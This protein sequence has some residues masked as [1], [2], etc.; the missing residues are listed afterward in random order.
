MEDEEFL[1]SLTSAWL[2]EER[3]A[4]PRETLLEQIARRGPEAMRAEIEPLVDYYDE[5]AGYLPEAGEIAEALVELLDNLAGDAAPACAR[6]QE[7]HAR[8]AEV[9]RAELG[10]LEVRPSYSPW[11]DSLRAQLQAF[12]RGQQSRAPIYEQLA[13]LEQL[14]S[15][16]LGQNRANARQ[17]GSRAS[18]PTRKVL[19]L[20]EQG[21]ARGQSA[22]R[23]LIAALE[24]RDLEGIGESL[25]SLNQAFSYLTQARELCELE[26]RQY[27]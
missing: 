14:F 18:E 10:C 19:E 20:S 15:A 2:G 21:Y 3:R 5:L 25:R 27:S 11:V 24:R 6:L 22:T 16:S 4:A 23:A 12:V 8:H 26:G 9:L 7:L 17:M 1:G 13:E